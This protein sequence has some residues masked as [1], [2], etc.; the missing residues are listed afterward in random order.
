M[1]ISWQ[2]QGDGVREWASFSKDQGKTWSPA[3]DVLF[4]KHQASR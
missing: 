2:A 3:F 4:R 1:R